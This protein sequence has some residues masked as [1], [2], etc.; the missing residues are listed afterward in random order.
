MQIERDA[1]G[2]WR[3]WEIF[4]DFETLN[5]ENPISKP[6]HKGEQKTSPLN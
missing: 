5:I 2:H 1:F 6:S 4:K 3:I